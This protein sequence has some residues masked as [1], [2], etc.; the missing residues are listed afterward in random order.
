MSHIRV[1]SVDRDVRFRRTPLLVKT[2]VTAAIL[3]CAVTLAAL[4][5]TTQE[6]KNECSVLSK[7]AASLEREHLVLAEKV[8]KLGTAESYV[9]IAEEEL[10]LVDPDTI[11]IE[12]E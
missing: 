11:I 6:V 7:T 4:H 10:G 12:S 9:Q 2:V 8:K 1:F 5:V 3:V